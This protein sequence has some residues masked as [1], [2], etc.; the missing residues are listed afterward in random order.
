MFWRLVKGALFR[1][2][3]KMLMIAFTIALGASLAAAMLNVMLDVG[4]K[5]NQE[6]KTYGAN[7]NVIPKEASLLDDLYGVNEGAG[8]SDRFL[9]ESELGNIKTIFWAF[10]I[11]DFAP[12]LDAKVRVAG[13]EEEIR[14]TGTWFAN[15]IDLSTGESLDT[16]IK[17]MK[18]WWTVTGEWVAD[19]DE[20]AVMAGCVLADKLGLDIG[21]SLIVQTGEKKETFTVKGVFDAG[22]EEDERI[23][24]PLRVVQDLTGEAGLVSNVEVSALTTPDNELSRRAAQNPNS[25]SVK[26]WETWYCTA[27]VSAICYQIEEVLTDSVA[28]PIRRVA[29][30]EGAILEKTRLLMLLITI[31]SVAGAALGISNLVTASVMERG[32]EIGLLKA[33]GANNASISRLVLTEIFI[34]GAVGGTAGYF[35]GLGF[36]QIIGRTVF[37]AAINIK[38]MVVPLVAI[39]ILAV[40]AAGSAPAIR[41]LLSLRPAEVLHGR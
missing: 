37:D 8:I 28:K 25:L 29:E 12:Y 16:G 22:S 6:L 34:T 40:T 38:P 20:S 4:D 23:Y 5:V 31:L 15:H 26:E 41:L 24:A 18:S 19:E 17:N 11:V 27:Y 9:R 30:S 14:L 7:I 33:I 39:L 32:R 35:T 3:G 36:A 13:E 1:Q 10:N 21:D 2:K